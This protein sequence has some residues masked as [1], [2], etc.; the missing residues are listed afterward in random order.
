MGTKVMYA[1]THN[2]YIRYNAVTGRSSN[3]NISYYVNTKT[4][5]K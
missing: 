2:C 5:N 1:S 4:Y 3:Y